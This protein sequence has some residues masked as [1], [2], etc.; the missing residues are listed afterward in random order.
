M[1]LPPSKFF[2]EVLKLYGI[3]PHNICPN[4]Y[5]ILAKFQ[6]FLEGYLRIEPDVRLFQWYFSCRPEYEENKNS[7]NCGS[8]T[9]ILRNQR[10]YPTFS[11]LDSIRYWNQNWFYHKNLSIGGKADGLPEFQD[12]AATNIDSWRDCV[13]INEHQD[14]LRMAQRIGKF[15]DSG[16][17]SSDITLSWL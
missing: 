6:A 5:T 16:L 8:A 12:G 1:S 11:P 7:C 9:F 4:S 17:C 2:L 10:K 14:L 3:Q 13:D 15:C